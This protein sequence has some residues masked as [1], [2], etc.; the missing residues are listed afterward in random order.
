MEMNRFQIFRSTSI[1]WLGLVLFIVLIFS[2]LLPIHPNDYWWYVRLGGEIATSGSIP[3]I[4]TYSFTQAGKPMVYHSWLAARLFWGLDQMGGQN[5]TILVRGI[6]LSLF[7]ALIWYNCRLVGAGPRLAAFL[8]ILNAFVASYNWG[9]RPQLFSYP[10]FGLA[11]LILWQWR[12]GNTWWVWLLPLIMALWVNLHGSFVLCF[13]LVGAAFVGGGGNRR[14]LLFAIGGMVVASFINPRGWGAWEY[15]ISLLTDPSSQ[16]LGT[17]WRPPT[18][19]KWQHALFFGWLLLIP[20]LV[21]N[22]RKSLSMTDWLWFLGFGWMAISGLRY[23]IWFVAIL[24]PMSGYMLAPLIG[25]RIDPKEV[26]GYPV[27]NGIIFLLL[28]VLPLS[29]MPGIREKWWEDSPPVLTSNTPVAAVEWLREHPELPG[30]IWSDLAFSSYLIYALPERPVWSDTRLELFPYEQ[31]EQYIE[32]TEAVPGWEDLLAEYEISMLIINPGEQERLLIALHKSEDWC[33]S[34]DDPASKI[35]T[36][37]SGS[38]VCT[39]D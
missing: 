7:S 29:F 30:P 2:L 26:E 38:D 23:V 12:K 16:Q 10:L 9:I 17:E 25:S 3:T 19:E 32:I 37:I 27:L 35:F 8:T 33:L 36:K 18:N 4:D 11:L 34:Y 24:T 1:V 5:V 39:H 6:L 31:W 21:S 20:L 14:I 13:L 22:S 15:V 28:L